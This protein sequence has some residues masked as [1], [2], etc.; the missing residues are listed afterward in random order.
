MSD[1]DI[2]KLI[3]AQDP[4][5]EVEK[6][7]RS[8]DIAGWSKEQAEKDAKADGITLGDDHWKVIDLLRAHYVEH[9]EEKGAREIAEMLDNAFKAQGGSRYL[10]QLFPGGPVAQGTRLAGVPVPHDAQSA[11]FG[12]SF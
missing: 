6:L 4:D 11:S 8:N 1:L 9:G 10:Y 7:S 3:A 2:N 12:S 5:V